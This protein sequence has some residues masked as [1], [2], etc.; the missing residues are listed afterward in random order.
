MLGLLR[1]ALLAVIGLLLVGTVVIGIG[2]E[3]TGI[4]EKASLVGIGAL[5]VMAS[6]RVRK[7][8]RTSDQAR[9]RTVA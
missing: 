3:N 6:I 2:S 7:I 5:L 8:G 1:V 4:I 9:P